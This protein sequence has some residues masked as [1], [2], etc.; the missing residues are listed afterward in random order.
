MREKLFFENGN[1]VRL[2][3]ILSHPSGQANAPTVIMC[4]GFS[5]NKGGRTNTQL[6][7][8]LNTHDIATFRFDFFGHGESDGRFDD[9]TISEATR[10][11][12]AASKFIKNRG[13]TKIALFGSSFGGQAS[14]LAASQT[15]EFYTLALKS[16]VSDYLGLLIAGDREMDI[17]SWKRSGYISI[18][19]ADSRILRLNYSFYEDAEKIRGYEAVKRIKTPTLI[20]H[21]NKDETVPLEQSK[22]AA[23]L[24]G[25]CRLEIVRGADHIYSQ[26]KHFEKMVKLL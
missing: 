20:V 17:S 14:L 11:V 9:I 6:E 23:G 4:H 3:G 16:P 1:G 19:G 8:I 15:S 26:P 12:M 10:D 25:D 24:I 18:T 5:T 22:I 13:H 7:E 21:G 2:C